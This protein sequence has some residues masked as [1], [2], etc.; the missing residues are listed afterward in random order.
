MDQKC[1]NGFM[2][3]INSQYSTFNRFKIT[4]YDEAT[5]REFLK[6]C[7]QKEVEIRRKQFREDEQ[8]KSL[9]N[10]AAKWLCCD[11]KVGLLLYGGVGNGKSTLSRAICKLI[12]MLYPNNRFDA[13]ENAPTIITALELAKI[14][15]DKNQ[16][17]CKIKECSKLIID[18]LGTEPP[19]IKSWGNE[20]SPLTETLYNRYDKQLF[21]IATSN[22]NDKE[23]KER[24]GIRIADRIEEMFDKLYFNGNSYRR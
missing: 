15:I 3:A 1:I 19:T 10:K 11:C 22:L 17:F 16:Q 9:L 8:I 20:I 6:I 21:T 12:E 4:D 2:N 24:Y 18:D 5:I 13:K 14:A 7:Y 23:I